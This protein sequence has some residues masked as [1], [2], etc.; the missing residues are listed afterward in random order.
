MLDLYR[1]SAGSGKTYTLALKYIWYYITIT[2]ENGPTRLRTDA[3]LA[4]SARHILAVTF[5]NKATNEMQMRI[6]DA[7]FNLALLRKKKKTAPDGTVELKDPDYLREICDGLDVSESEV[8][9]VCGVALSVLLEN[10][11]D[12]NVSTIDSFFQ[13]VLRTFTYE[14]DLN[15]TYQVEL[16]SDYLSQIGVDATLEE[17]DANEADKDTP[18]WVRTLMDRTEKGKWNIFTRNVGSRTSNAEN[19]YKSFIQSV[20]KME[21][22]E[23]KDIR[24]DVEKYFK[25][26]GGDMATLYNDLN[27]SI[28]KPVKEAF[29]KMR[30]LAKSA[31]RNLPP[32]MQEA[33]A[34]SNTGKHTSFYKKLTGTAS[35]SPKWDTHPDSSSFSTL[36][37]DFLDSKQWLAWAAKNPEKEREVRKDMERVLEAYDSW[38]RML[39]SEEFNHWRLYSKNFPYYAMFGIV[40]RKR[41]EYL[42]ENNAVELGET[43][44]ILRSVI[45]ESDTPFIYERLGTYLNHFL[46]DEFQD[47]SRMQ[48]HNLSPLLHESMSRDNGNLIIGDA[49]Q[50]IYRFRNADP[51]LITRVV[52]DEFGDRVKARGMIPSENTNYRSDLR[53]VRFNNSFFEYFTGALDDAAEPGRMTFGGLYSNVVQRPNNVK[54]EGYV[55][56]RVSRARKQDALT[57]IVPQIPVLV[58][59]LL[60]RGYRQREIAVLVQTHNEGQMVIDAFVE[61]NLADPDKEPIRFV[62]EQS[63]KINSSRAVRI[64]TGVLEN[65]ARGSNPKIRTGDE[66]LKKGVGNWADMM[67]NF[68]YFAMNHPDLS[69]ADCLDEYLLSG[70]DYNA[71]SEL[72]DKLQSLAIPALVE[73]VAAAFLPAEVRRQDAVYIA[74]FQ[75]L[76]LEYC[77]SHP[78]DIGSFLKWWERKSQSA[79][80]ASPANTDAVQIVTIHK[81]K[82]LQYECVIVPFADW[83]M[84]DTIPS[85]KK[86]WRWVRPQAVSHPNLPLPPYIPVETSAEMK[87]TR[88]APLLEEYFD[89]LKMDRLNSAYVAFT[90]AIKELY[91]FS[92][93]PPESSGKKKSDAGRKLCMGNCLTDFFHEMSGRKPEP[94][95]PEEVSPR[96]SGDEIEMT[97]EPFVAKVGTLPESVGE[98]RKEDEKMLLIDSY[99]SVDV[100]GFLKY[101]TDALPGLAEAAEEDDAN[102]D[103]LDPRSEGTLK[104][105]VL[106]L[107]NVPGDLP[108]AIRHLRI[109]GILPDSLAAKVEA[110]LAEALSRPE[111]SQWFDGTARVVNERPVLKGGKV[112]RRPDR[113]LLY[114]DGSAVVIDYKFGEIPKGNKHKKQI[115]LYVRRLSETGRFTRVTGYLWYVNQNTIIPVDPAPR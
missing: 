71:L 64:I 106:E 74:A 37:L 33:T 42:D 87:N 26:H 103:D 13:Q 18:F 16:D 32:D 49:K 110:D 90:R 76:V 47:T 102:I 24:G 96:L 11:S 80:I 101:R 55:E 88:H 65:M 52:P 39:V 10:Y 112:T 4:D 81:S 109:T 36:S 63:L 85:G 30:K 69:I 50:S 98:G 2:P 3:E 107:V 40:S 31:F 53:V 104:H 86:E 19:P 68:K 94:D 29:N 15:D 7:L 78:T 44:M 95:S 59:R 22:E 72:L 20:K 91:I 70:T 43:S 25:K 67:A 79:S 5:T 6:V 92:I 41:Q 35:G 21:N 111:V 27:D 75:D 17:I 14:S 45:G 108:D 12:F 54:P 114:H 23:Y 46:I 1:A 51:S 73:S 93:A 100:P 84:S 66:R 57:E 34:R 9:R 97:G 28:V 82:G 61:R 113:L 115:G 58:E 62:S 99:D 60:D 105:A 89:Q 8:S 56:V 83:D 77:D 38:R 48:W